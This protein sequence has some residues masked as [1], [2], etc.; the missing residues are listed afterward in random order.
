MLGGDG[1]RSIKGGARQIHRYFTSKFYPNTR[2]VEGM[3]GQ[4]GFSRRDPLRGRG[5][6]EQ[7]RVA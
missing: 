7:N 3:E 5:S 2:G 4:N 6:G 1:L